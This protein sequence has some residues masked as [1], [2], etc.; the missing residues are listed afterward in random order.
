MKVEIFACPELP[1]RAIGAETEVALLRAAI[2]LE[3]AERLSLKQHLRLAV[4]HIAALNGALDD[5]A[6]L[7]A[8]IA[9][10]G[11]KYDDAAARKVLG[12]GA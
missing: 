8:T 4:N 11:T 12:P 2:D 10:C 9:I 7:G 3:H 5:L 6:S 1:R